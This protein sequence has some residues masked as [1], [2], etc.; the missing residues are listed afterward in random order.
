[1]LMQGYDYG[2][3]HFQFVNWRNLLIKQAWYRCL[4]HIR[5]PSKSIADI[6]ALYAPSKDESNL[7]TAKAPKAWFTNYTFFDPSLY[8]K[9]ELWREKEVLKWFTQYGKNFFEQLD[10]WDIDW[11]SYKMIH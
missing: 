6:N 7:R 2:L 5:N 10:I 8:Q 3:L 4:E 11:G 9:A 1:M